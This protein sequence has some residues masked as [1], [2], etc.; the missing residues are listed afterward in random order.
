MPSRAVLL[1]LFPTILLAAGPVK[2]A[3][4]KA[5]A[6]ATAAKN[7]AAAKDLAKLFDDQWQWELREYPERA[8]SVGDPRY[9]DK[10]ADLSFEAIDRRKAHSVETLA[11]LKKIGRE[12]L[13]EEDRL[14]YDVFARELETSIEG[15][16]FPT[17]LMPIN[18]QYGIHTHFAILAGQTRFSTAKDYRDYL[19]RLSA[20]PKQVDQTIALMDRGKQ[21]GWI[22][23]RGA[24]ARGTR[25][26]PGADLSRIRRRARTGRRSPVSRRG[27]RKPTG[28]RCASRGGAGSPTTC[29]PPT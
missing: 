17:E 2:T 9:N 11:R 27:S 26:D 28:K 3:R 16:R 25:C 12:V 6:A 22:L 15:D 18:Q 24:A 29:S 5:S 8:T 14:S 10:L 19:A 23:P 13:S 4:P 7:A 20:F 1:L 21:K